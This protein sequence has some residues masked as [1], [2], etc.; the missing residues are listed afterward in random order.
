[1]TATNRL[2]T[3]GS[4]SNITHCYGSVK[5]K[6][7]MCTS[8]TGTVCNNRND[9][10][11]ITD[12]STRSIYA[13]NYESHADNDSP[14]SQNAFKN[15][16]HT[17]YRPI[18]F[19]SVSGEVDNY[20][21]T[22]IFPINTLRLYGIQGSASGIEASPLTYDVPTMPVID[23]NNLVSQVGD[24]LDGHMKTKSNILVTVAEGLKTIAMLKS[25]LQ[26]LKDLVRSQSITQ[27]LNNAASIHLIYKYGWK[28]LYRDVV[29]FGN[30]H[31]AVSEHIKYLEDNR[32]TFRSLSARQ[33]DSVTYGNPTTQTYGELELTFTPDSFRRTAVVSCQSLLDESINIHS[34]SKYMLQGLGVDKVV[35]AVWDVIPFSFV[36]DWLINWRSFSK[37]PRSK[38]QNHNVRR[39][40]YS[41]KETVSFTPSTRL[42]GIATLYDGITSLDLHNV[43]TSQVYKTTYTRTAGFPPGSETA[44]VFKTLSTTNLFDGAALIL[45]RV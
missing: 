38:F 27:V 45:Q 33:T 29:A 24:S 16:I 12:L 40:G 11:S 19:P 42:R 7:T 41:T 20:P 31:N 21:S 22:T 44:G 10:E 37:D 36:V 32:S 13:T 9:S 25:P 6:S 43:G 1:M 28:Q 8:N 26:P 4:M 18:H 30:M 23:W 35:E 17:K 39:L 15:A 2:R 14:N 34:Y 5:Y 3:R